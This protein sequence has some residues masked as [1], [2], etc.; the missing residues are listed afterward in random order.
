MEVAATSLL[1]SYK[2]LKLSVGSNKKEEKMFR[3]YYVP[4]R[5]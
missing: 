5:D 3:V 2:G 4:I 1:R